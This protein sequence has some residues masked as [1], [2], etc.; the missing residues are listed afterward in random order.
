MLDNEDED[1]LPKQKKART[2]TPKFKPSL[3]KRTDQPEAVSS[4]SEFLKGHQ[5]VKKMKLQPFDPFKGCPAQW[6]S[7]F[8]REFCQ[9]ASVD[10]LGYTYLL[11]LLKASEAKKWHFRYK[12]VYK[13]WSKLKNDFISHFDKFYIKKLFLLKSTIDREQQKLKEFVCEQMK[14]WSSFFPSLSQTELNT[15]V[16]S[17]LTTEIASQLAS[18]V[19]C[20]KDHFIEYCEMI[21]NWNEMSG[22]EEENISEYFDQEED[23]DKAANQANA[24]AAAGAKKAKKAKKAAEAKQLAEKE[25]VDTSNDDLDV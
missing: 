5:I 25:A 23:D 11:H 16:I 6:I 18:Y 2:S 10:D 13:S 22:G 19:S 24:K 8:E 14:L 4:L 21:E 20:D 1:V 17:G 9:F 7:T 15:A 12:P 3:A